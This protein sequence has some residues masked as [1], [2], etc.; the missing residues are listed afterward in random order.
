MLV[1]SAAALPVETIDAIPSIIVFVAP[2]L[3]NNH[4]DDDFISRVDIS[5]YP[6]LRRYFCLLFILPTGMHCMS[7]STES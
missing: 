1:P 5:D 6:M 7:F 4:H 2:G 3:V